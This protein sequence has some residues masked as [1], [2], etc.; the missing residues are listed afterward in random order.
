MG[1]A[2]KGKSEGRQ[3]DVWVHFASQNI[4]SG[5]IDQEELYTDQL[6]VRIP[7]IYCFVL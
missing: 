3:G 4:Y 6:K 5:S 2:M 1:H 7:R